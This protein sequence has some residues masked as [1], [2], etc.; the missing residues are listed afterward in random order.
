MH[1]ARFA[2]FLGS[3]APIVLTPA[4]LGHLMPP[5]SLIALFEEHPLGVGYTGSLT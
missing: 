1:I 3:T 4:D 2:I 5:L